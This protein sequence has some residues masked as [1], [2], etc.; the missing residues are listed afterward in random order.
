MA[1]DND[2][3]SSILGEIYPLALK[4]YR[5]KWIKTISENN[6]NIKKI[7]DMYFEMLYDIVFDKNGNFVYPKSA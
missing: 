1:K 7:L 3:L 2:P 4:E 6:D 5:A